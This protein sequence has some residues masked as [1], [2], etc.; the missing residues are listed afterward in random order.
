[1]QEAEESEAEWATRLWQKYVEYGEL[2]DETANAGV[3]VLV[4]VTKA[5]QFVCA[6]I[7]TVYT[8]LYTQGSCCGSLGGGFG[9]CPPQLDGIF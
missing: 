3:R 6:C 9:S 8:V 5:G 7:S 1:M 4:A 2:I